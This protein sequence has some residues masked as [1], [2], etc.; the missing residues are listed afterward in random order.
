[1]AVLGSVSEQHL[2]E[3]LHPGRCDAFRHDGWG[4]GTSVANR[5]RLRA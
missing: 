2:R 1:M 3:L 4:L 5:G